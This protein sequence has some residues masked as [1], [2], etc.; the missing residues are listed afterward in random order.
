MA[1]PFQLVQLQLSSGTDVYCI[2]IVFRHVFKI[3]S[4][5]LSISLYFHMKPLSPDCMDVHEIWYLSIFW[6]SVKIQVLLKYGK[7]NR[8]FTQRPIYIYDD[9][10]EFFLGWGMFQT[11]FVGK[12]KTHVLCSETAYRAI[13]EIMWKNMVQPDRPHLTE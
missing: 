2:W 5:I 6:N 10:A 7:N 11:K 8:Y 4:L 9:L 3:A 12:V 1:V 13:Y